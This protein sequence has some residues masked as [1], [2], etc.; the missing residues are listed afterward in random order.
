MRTSTNTRFS[1]AGFHHMALRARN[2]DASLALHRRNGLS[3]GTLLG[4][5]R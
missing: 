5:G 2:F 1:Q 4:G 3:R